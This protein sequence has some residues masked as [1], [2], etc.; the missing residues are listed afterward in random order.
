MSS[1]PRAPTA[2]SAGGIWVFPSNLAPPRHSRHSPQAAAQPPLSV[3]DLRG[4]GLSSPGLSSPGLSSPGLPSPGLSSR[5]GGRAQPHAELPEPP[6]AARAPLISCWRQPGKGKGTAEQGVTPKA[7]VCF[8]FSMFC[9]ILG[10]FP[11]AR[12]RPRSIQTPEGAARACGRGDTELGREKPSTKPA[13]LGREALES[14][15]REAAGGEAAA[16][17]VHEV[18]FALAERSWVW[19]GKLRHGGG[20]ARWSSETG[21]ALQ[22][23][24]SA[25]QAARG[26]TFRMWLLRH[27]AARRH[28]ELPGPGEVAA[29][30]ATRHQPRCHPPG[31]A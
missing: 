3:P 19:M 2:T 10:K 5:R 25:E 16:L 15:T 22:P 30:G 9:F 24:A 11:T 7:V 23:P 17:H 21:A 4:R 12:L 1:P 14:P 28:G 29:P 18:A 27:T 8:F 26:E 13:E 6:W 20:E 31:M